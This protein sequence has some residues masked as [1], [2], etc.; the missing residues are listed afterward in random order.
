MTALLWLRD[1]LRLHD[2]PALIA[3]AA[4]DGPLI[5]VYILEHHPALRPLGGA[6]RWW[7][8]NSLKS[9]SEALDQRGQRLILRQGNPETILPQ[10][11]ADYGVRQVFWSRRYHALTLDRD[12]KS[13]S[14]L[15]IRVLSYEHSL[16][17]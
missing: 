7:L 5:I 14:Q 9:L 2:H 15:R 17:H 8:H 4:H 12:I 16:N 10:M 13:A 3:A 11:V 1:D 6:S